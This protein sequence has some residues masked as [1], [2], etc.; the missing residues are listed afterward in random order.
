VDGASRSGAPFAFWWRP[1]TATW[2]I[3]R[4]RTHA[5]YDWRSSR[6]G[7][8][9]YIEV[10]DY[11]RDRDGFRCANYTQTIYG[12]GR[13]EVASGVACRQPNGAWAF[14]G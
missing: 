5:R 2:L 12:R 9:G 11:F 6:S 14:V 8:Y 7:A 1:R 3:E 10:N 4:G 13:P